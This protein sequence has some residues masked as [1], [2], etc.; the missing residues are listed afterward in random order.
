M[1]TVGSCSG[2]RLFCYYYAGLWCCC[3]SVSQDSV[4]LFNSVFNRCYS[5]TG[6]F[7][8]RLGGNRNYFRMLQLCE[9]QLC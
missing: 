8:C 5:Y 9:L 1:V 2:I 7:S 4:G 3:F 6:L